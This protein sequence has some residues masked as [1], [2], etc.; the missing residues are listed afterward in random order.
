M[1]RHEA[2]KQPQFGLAVEV[3][4]KEKMKEPQK[5]RRVYLCKN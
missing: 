1:K 5:D 4:A 2:I 3:D